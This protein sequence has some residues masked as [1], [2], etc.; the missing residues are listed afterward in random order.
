MPRKK[1]S[2]LLA[3]DERALS[4]A[5]CIKLSNEGYNVDVVDNGSSAISMIEKNKY[6]L[7]LLDLVMPVVDGFGV[8]AS[9]KTHDYKGDVIVLSNLSK[10]EDRKRTAEFGAKDFIVKADMP[11]TKLAE[12]IKGYLK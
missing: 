9:M 3:E 7:I 4:K 12:T 6:D 10:T 2:I 11:I 1:K 5:L 8:L